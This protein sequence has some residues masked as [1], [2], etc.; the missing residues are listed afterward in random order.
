MTNITL[1][2]SSSVIFA[3]N[4]TDIIIFSMNNSF[5]VEFELAN[6]ELQMKYF[7]SLFVY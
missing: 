5:Y 2:Y 6:V 1:L 4:I 7:C 3:T